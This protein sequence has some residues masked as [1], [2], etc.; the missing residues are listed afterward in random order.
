MQRPMPN[1]WT[2]AMTVLMLF[3][4][5]T[6]CSGGMRM[7][8]ATQDAVSL[9]TS[10]QASI[11]VSL[12]RIADID[13]SLAQVNTLLFETPISSDEASIERL[14]NVPSKSIQKYT[15][16]VK[17]EGPYSQPN[18]Q[19]PNLKIYVLHNAETL[20]AARSISNARY[21]TLMA[22]VADLGGADGKVIADRYK[23]VKTLKNQIADFEGQI[24]LLETEAGKESLDEARKEAIAREVSLLKASID[25]AEEKVAPQEKELF[26]AITK[27]G[28]SGVVETNKLG[29]AT[30][31]YKMLEHAAL[32]EVESLVMS[33]VVGI[34]TVQALPN[35]P[36]GDILDGGVEPAHRQRLHLG[37]E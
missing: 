35:L 13:T 25:A 32:M 34:Q 26:D 33:I 22:G 6:G 7:I 2:K 12:D 20:P 8:K 10:E 30:N 21:K 11:E 3:G 4:L 14:T 37:W 24:S 31:I 18:R 5:I 23:E 28:N 19:V 27:L 29:V 1:V 17:A 15:Q 36:A 9:T 16:T